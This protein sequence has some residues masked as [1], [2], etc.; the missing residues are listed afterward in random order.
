MPTRSFDVVIIGGGNAG[1]GVTVATREAGLTVAM[2]EPDLLGGT[3]PN[4]G[5]MPKKVL[6]AAAHALDEIERAKAHHITVGKP[7][8]DWAALIDREKAMIAGIPD[9]LGNLMN[10]RG[11]E[12]IRGRGRFAEPNA[13]AVG[14]ETLE[15]KHIVIATGSTPCR[16]PFPGAE[17]MIT[18][19]DV[20]NERRL[21][22]SVVFVGGGVIALEFS[23]VYAR[24]GAKVTILEALPRLLDSMDADAVGQLRTATERIGVAIH[25]GVEIRRVER[26]GDRLRIVYREG[27]SER[28]VEAERVVNGAGRVADVDGL[29]LAAGN[30]ALERGQIALDASLRASNTSVHA[31]GDAVATSPQLSPIATYEGR[32]VGRNIVD[33][34]RHT[35]DYRSVPAC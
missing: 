7:S 1:M 9:S 32:I 22:A 30:V 23:H 10:R 27:G 6:V 26:A 14:E 19:D 20:L 15:A 5:C 11:V 33:G 34:P 18:S 25:A 28:T 24:A 2:L 31:C 17:L 16:L 3:C 4:R 13:V 12:V 8:L 29:D 21:P 35:P